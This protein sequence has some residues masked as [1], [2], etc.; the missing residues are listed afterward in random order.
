[1]TTLPTYDA[2]QLAGLLEA[3]PGADSVELKLTVPGVDHRALAHDL[4]IDTLDAVVRQVAFV[5]TADLRL[6]ASGLVLRV[7]RTQRKPGDVTVKLRPMLPADVPAELRGLPGLK[8][9]VDASPAG[10]TCSCSLTASVSDRKARA[11]LLGQRPFAD[12]LT[13]EQ[14]AVVADRLPP[15]TRMADLLL[16]G[17]VHLLKCRFALEDQPRKMIAELWFLPGGA[18]LLELSTK[19]PPARAFQ[20]AAETK[21]VLTR[22]AIDL[23]A[24]Q[25]LKTRSV[26]AALSAEAR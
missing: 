19:A 7:R 14:R 10:Y 3:L 5:D 8:V 13:P 2:D 9:E 20:T 24:P 11:V 18:R 1:M 16:L 4:G 22:H 26:L 12:L 21:L 17:P 15:G 25:E 23:G 6:S